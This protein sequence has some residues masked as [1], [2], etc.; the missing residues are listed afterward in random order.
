MKVRAR[1]TVARMAMD[2]V[3]LVRRGVREV[4]PVVAALEED[5][6]GFRWG[7]ETRVGERGVTLSGGQQQRLCIARAIAV[8]PEVILMD[9]PCSAL[10]PIATA[11]IEELIDELNSA[12]ISPQ[13]AAKRLQEGSG[14]SVELSG[15]GPGP[16]AL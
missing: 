16:R 8:Q 10:D 3:C 9:E 6:A 14:A 7:L 11:K 2:S 13:K 15:S 1:S 4:A 12:S 5:L